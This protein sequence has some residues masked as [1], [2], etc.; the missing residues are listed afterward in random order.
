MLE[1]NPPWE[2]PVGR[3]CAI[4]ALLHPDPQAYLILYIENSSV[5]EFIL[6]P[7]PSSDLD[8]PLNWSTLRK[9]VDFGL[10]CS[11][12]LITFVLID[13]NSLCYRWYIEELGLDYG[14]FNQAS[15]TNFAG[16]AAGALLFIPLVYNEALVMIT[17]VDLFFVHQHARMNG[18]FIFMQS[19][20]STGGP[21]AAGYVV[22]AMGWRW[23]WWLI[24][25]FVGVDLILVICFFEESKYIPTIIGHSGFT[26]GT[27][28]IETKGLDEKAAETQNHL[29]NLSISSRPN[30]KSLRQR[31]ALV[32]KTEQPI[33]QH[34]YQPVVVLVTFPVVAFTALTYGCL[35]AWFSANGSA[36]SYFLIYPP[37]NF[38]AAAIGLFHLGGFIG[39]VIATLFIPMFND[40]LIVYLARRNGGI[41]EPEMRLWT[42][43]P[44]VFLNCIGLLVFGIGLGR[45]L[46]WILLSIGQAIFGFGFI[47]TADA[48]LTY[49]TDCYPDILGDALIAVVFVRNGLAMIIRFAFTKWLAGMGIQNTFILIGVIALALGTLPIVFMVYGKRVRV[50][51]ATNFG[52]IYKNIRR[53]HSSK[54]FLIPDQLGGGSPFKG[55]NDWFLLFN[56][57]PIAFIGVI[58]AQKLHLVEL[59]SELLREIIKHVNY[60]IDLCALSQTT[61]LF[62]YLVKKRLDFNLRYIFKQSGEPHT[63]RQALRWACINGRDS[64][65]RRLLEARIEIPMPQYEW[66][67]IILAAEKGHTQVVKAFIDH[68]VDPNPFT[69]FYGDGRQLETKRYGNPLIAAIKGGH[70]SVV[71][72]LINHGVDLECT[73]Q[74]IEIMQPL[75]LATKEN[76]LSIASLLLDHGCNPHTPN[77]RRNGPSEDTAWTIATS[78]AHDILH[79]FIDKGVPPAFAK[80]PSSSPDP[81]NSDHQKLVQALRFGNLPLARCLFEQGVKLKMPYYSPCAHVLDYV[82]YDNPLH[83]VGCAVGKNPKESEFL[84]G[85]IDLDDIVHG[86]S[87][88]PLVSL[89]VG[90]MHGGHHALVKS[91]LDADWS[92]KRPIVGPEEWKDHLSSCM[93]IAISGGYIDLVSLLLDYGADPRGVVND[94]Q[95]R[96]GYYPPIFMAATRQDRVDILR[97]LLDRGANPFPRQPKTLFELLIYN[98]PWNASDQKAPVETVR[99]L[100]EKDVLVPK[101]GDSRDTIMTA[102]KGGPDIFKLVAQHMG[103]TPQKGNPCHEVA[104]LTA[105]ESGDTA[106]MEWFLE[107]GF[108]PNTP[109]NSV[110]CRSSSL[111]AIAASLDRR[112]GIAEY[113]VDLL[114][115]YGA[116]IGWQSPTSR[117]TPLFMVVNGKFGTGLACRERAT[118]LLLRKGADPFTVHQ[119]KI[120]IA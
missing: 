115:Q 43:I 11:Y 96:D 77:F 41:F 116:D 91:L 92:T 31:L 106:T 76:H 55:Q 38:G 65:V 109:G 18:I 83:V 74:N 42:M 2:R 120:L 21:I 46:H 67:P 93:M 95:S 101:M 117:S 59:P 35:L 15:G 94:R 32:T 6:S 5:A 75:F 70:E 45:G 3:Q 61:H 87:L 34:F 57:P 54:G 27:E 82:H 79:M 58:M 36:G 19:L 47:V 9:A 22:V 12:V 8:D 23:M 80:R 25:I 107:A 20:G 102:A 48:V 1:L 62:H 68:G 105:V 26:K 13:V 16:L 97:L 28:V 100:I 64:S 56:L 40:W 52:R 30:R 78:R 103:I 108:D 29:R 44:A 49:L 24:A 112:S 98:K 71:A 60:S 81:G 17:I 51:S 89:M 10:T 50:K 118:A 7:T 37:Y 69:G 111:L 86:D 73:L 90:A 88:R 114:L 113:T 53:Y 14:T 119:F 110:R 72:L 39:T 99:L 63:E 4:V 66:H 104:F 85:K 33:L 84:L